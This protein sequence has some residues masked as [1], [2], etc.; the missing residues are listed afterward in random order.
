MKAIAS[1][2]GM[3]MPFKP[4]GLIWMVRQ[5]PLVFA[6]TTIFAV[7]PSASQPKSEKSYDW[8][9]SG[10]YFREH[11]PERAMDWA[12]D[13]KQSGRIES[14]SVLGAVIH[15]GNC[16]DFMDVRSTRIL[17]EAFPKFI[18]RQESLG[19]QLPAYEARDDGDRDFLR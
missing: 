11:G 17:A 14:P 10:I 2:F 3:V 13:Q 1:A 4:L 19:R 6:C 8:L 9:G 12:I 15:L 16:F 5:V 7:L 18:E